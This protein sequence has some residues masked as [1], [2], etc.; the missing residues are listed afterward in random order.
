M[1]RIAKRAINNYCYAIYV[2][3]MP[4]TGG[5]KATPKGY[6]ERRSLFF[7]HSGSVRS[8]TTSNPRSKALLGLF[9]LFHLCWHFRRKSC[10]HIS[11]AENVYNTMRSIE[12]FL[13]VRE[14]RSCHVSTRQA[15]ECLSKKDKR[16]ERIKEQPQAFDFRLLTLISSVGES[17]RSECHLTA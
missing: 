11:E 7:L 14:H 5:R 2:E 13:P 10:A 4:A 12:M 17:I 9:Y 15:R 6:S 8:K 3:Y 16:K 1:F